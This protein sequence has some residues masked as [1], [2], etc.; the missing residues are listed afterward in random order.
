M[1]MSTLD[2]APA[3]P[4]RLRPWL[5]SR[6]TQ[7]YLLGLIAAL[8]WGSYMA[9]ARSGISSG[10]TATDMAFLRFVPAGILM[11]PW[12]LLNRPATLGGVGIGRSLILCL[13]LGPPFILFGVGGYNFAPLAHGVVIMPSSATIGGLLF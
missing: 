8:I 7:G 10:L 12:L 3:R 13:V 9:L 1:M 5:A 11:L 4:G 2:A 6:E